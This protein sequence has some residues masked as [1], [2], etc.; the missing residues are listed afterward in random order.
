MNI[1]KLSSNHY[2]HFGYSLTLIPQAK[3]QFKAR[4]I[5]NNVQIIVPVPPDADS[6]KFKSTM[7]MWIR[8]LGGFN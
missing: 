3:S 6:P 7:G 2:S 1:L 4:S 8:G 5:A